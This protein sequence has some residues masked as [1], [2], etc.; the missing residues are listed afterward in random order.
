MPW[1]SDKFTAMDELAYKAG[2][3]TAPD[4]GPNHD[5]MFLENV[6]KSEYHQSRQGQLDR[7][8]L[9]AEHMDYDELKR[10]KM[11]AMKVQQ[12]IQVQGRYI[13]KNYQAGTNSHGKF[14]SNID[15]DQR[16]SLENRANQASDHSG[17]DSDDMFADDDDEF[18]RQLETIRQQR[19]NELKQQASLNNQSLSELSGKHPSNLHSHDANE[20]DQL[21]ASSQRQLPVANGVKEIIPEEWESEVKLPSKHSTVFLLVYKQGNRAS[22][23]MLK[24]LNTL[25]KRQRGVKM[26]VIL[27]STALAHVPEQHCPILMCYDK[28]QVVGSF[29]KLDHFRGSSTTAL[30]I[31]WKLAECGIIKTTLLEDPRESALFD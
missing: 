13:G 22:E 21:T 12:N 14:L 9:I 30:D 20:I 15:D 10:G 7:A 25:A 11:S 28:D 5:K 17:D 23:I 6:E 29:A 16:H 19:I 18:N 26:C 3:D 24:C 8:Q 2:I 1:E 31:E 4:K 27:Y